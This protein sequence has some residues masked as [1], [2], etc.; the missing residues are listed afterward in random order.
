[1]DYSASMDYLTI[2]LVDMASPKQT[3]RNG[4]TSQQASSVSKPFK[5]AVFF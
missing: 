4:K 5:L 3:I 1:M 2:Q